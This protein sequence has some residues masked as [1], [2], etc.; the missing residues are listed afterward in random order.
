MARRPQPLVRPPLQTVAYVGDDL[1]GVARRDGEVAAPVGL[2]L[3]FQSTNGVLEEQG[4]GAEVGVLGDAH[5]AFAD[6][7]GGYGRVVVQTEL[8]DIGAAQITEK[9]GR[10]VHSQLNRVEHVHVDDLTRIVE[11]LGEVTEA[12]DIV[13]GEPEVG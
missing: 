6:L 3:H 9:G 12:G 2:V 5:G 10:E 11:T 8:G 4:D 1:V 13:C 7:G